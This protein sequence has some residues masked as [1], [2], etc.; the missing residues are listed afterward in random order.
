M[1]NL[2]NQTINISLQEPATFT[3]FSFVTFLFLKCW[4]CWTAE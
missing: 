3:E 1:Q 2:E 4:T